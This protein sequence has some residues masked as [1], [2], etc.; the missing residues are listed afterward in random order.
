[1]APFCIQ[2]TYTLRVLYIMIILRLGIYVK[3]CL[4]YFCIYR[5][6]N[7]MHISVINKT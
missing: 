5:K 7:S 4:S 1:M 2:F 3:A 6:V